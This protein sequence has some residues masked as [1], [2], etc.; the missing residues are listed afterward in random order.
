MFTVGV[1]KVSD[2]RADLTALEQFWMDRVGATSN[3]Y[4]V[5]LRAWRSPDDKIKRGPLKRVL[6]P[7][8]ERDFCAKSKQV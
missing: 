7:G 2:E 5:S 6:V 4:N 3:L 1:L 8:K